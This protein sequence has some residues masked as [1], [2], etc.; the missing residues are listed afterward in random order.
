MFVIGGLAI[1]FGKWQR[2]VF[3]SDYNGNVCGSDVSGMYITYPRINEDFLLNYGKT[4]PATYSFFGMC[5][6]G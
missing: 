3:G 5:V 6:Q 2:L 1:R 4:N